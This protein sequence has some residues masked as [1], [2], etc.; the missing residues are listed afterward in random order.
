MEK[1]NL[2]KHVVMC[3]SV[4]NL[5]FRFL[6]LFQKVSL[7]GSNLKR[8]LL[9]SRPRAALLVALVGGKEAENGGKGET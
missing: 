6:A 3:T 9:K 1:S 8:V 7:F 4:F 5:Y 2:I